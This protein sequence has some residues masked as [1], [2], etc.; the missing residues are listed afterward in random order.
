MPPQA[1]GGGLTR[2]LK[3]KVVNEEVASGLV[4]ISAS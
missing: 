4:K 1:E 2:N 3:R